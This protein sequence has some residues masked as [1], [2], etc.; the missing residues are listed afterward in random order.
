M[1]LSQEFIISKNEICYLKIFQNNET[2]ILQKCE[3]KHLD[4][5]FQ[6]MQ[7]F[8]FFFKKEGV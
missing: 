3:T 5:T 4:L 6:I 8:F 2:F 1:Y 7:D